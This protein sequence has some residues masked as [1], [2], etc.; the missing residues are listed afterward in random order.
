ML[1][2]VGGTELLGGWRGEASLGK[3]AALSRFAPLFGERPAALRIS[4]SV[5]W[6]SALRESSAVGGSNVLCPV[7]ELNLV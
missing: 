1:V 5:S 7:L 3:A 6:M 4:A 2:E